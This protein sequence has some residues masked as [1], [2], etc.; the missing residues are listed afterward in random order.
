MLLA[1]ALPLALSCKGG[2]GS[3]A[4]GSMAAA[5]ALPWWLALCHALLPLLAR[6]SNEASARFPACLPSGP[7]LATLGIWLYPP[8]A[9]FLLPLAS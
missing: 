6:E 4:A 9:P 7:T 2:A 3:G 5:A 1:P 8:I